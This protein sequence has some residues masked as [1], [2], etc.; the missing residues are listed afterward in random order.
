MD[1]RAL[2]FDVNGTLVDIETN[3]GMEE[4]YRAIAHFLTY[5]GIMLHRGEVRER[6]FALMQAQRQR[7]AE[8]FPEWDAGTLW[9]EFIEATASDFTRALPADYL[10]QL[11]RMLAELHRG[12][13]RR[14]LRLFPQVQVTLD[15]LRSDY[16]LAVVSDAQRLYAIPELNAVGL[17]DYFD[18]IIVSGN[19]G[20]RKP[21]PRLFRQALAALQLQPD[22]ALFIGNDPYHDIFGA[23]QAGM[24]AILIAY[25]PGSFPAQAIAPDYTIARFEDL[26]QV[27]SHFLALK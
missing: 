7:S 14:R 24:R 19:Y 6:Y 27:I 23:Q 26:P 8:T 20:Y 21:D 10:A 18:P 2:L 3:E 13:A 25:Q 9:Q 22:Q 12:I 1:I 4:I 5:Q 16:A 17:Q 15:Q 11:P